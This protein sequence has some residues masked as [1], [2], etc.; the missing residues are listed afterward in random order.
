MLGV[1]Q[2]IQ[3]ICTKIGARIFKI[4]E[5]MTKKIELKVSNPTQK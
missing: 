2:K 1:F 4:N 3:E 5:E